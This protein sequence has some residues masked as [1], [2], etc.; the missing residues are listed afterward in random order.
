ME[1][2]KWYNKK[3]SVCGLISPH[4]N[5]DCLT[6][7]SKTNDS[8]SWIELIYEIIWVAYHQEIPDEFKVLWGLTKGIIKKNK[9]RHELNRIGKKE[10]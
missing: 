5:E 8:M 10:S 2:D 3:C 9:E 4:H 6:C 1:K 7:K